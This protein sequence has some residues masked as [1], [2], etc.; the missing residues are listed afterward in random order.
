MDK[1]LYEILGV[2]KEATE[3]EIRKAFLK[4]AK[5]FHPDVNP[6]N[7]EAEQKFKEVNFAYEVL[8]DPKKKAQYD[9]MRANPFA[10]SRA[11]AGAG[12]N[13]FGGGGFDP[14]MFQDLGL[15]DLFEEIFGRGGGGG[16]PFSGAGRGRAQGRG[17]ARPG[18]D[19]E[20]QI[21][22]SFQEAA[23]GGE[24]QL[25]FT[26]GKRL[27]VKIP[28]GVESGSKIRLS[29]QGDPGAGGAP[30]GDLIITLT[31]SPH[32]IFS[33]EGKDVVMK[34]PVTFAEAVLG[35]E[36]EVPTLDNKVHLKLPP[37]ISSGQRLKLGGK[38]IKAKDGS[39]GDQFV[40]ISIRVP[41][42]PDADY[43]EAAKK[44]QGNSFNPRT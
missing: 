30:A 24:R 32:A 17:F 2:K 4:A 6:N 12:G 35:A 13:P 39:R 3:G 5:K 42:Q 22:I 18:T 44:L 16:G 27:T 15:G 41:K 43:L 21:T 38:G 14:E 28:E 9:Q 31:V 34:L 40:E 26:N 36:V 11:G 1:D 10:R 7:K 25:E 33:R 20:T 29:G 37:G 8:K 23:R 19:R